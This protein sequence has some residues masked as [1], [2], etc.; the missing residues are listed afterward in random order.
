[1]PTDSDDLDLVITI[2]VA[3]DAAA[4]VVAGLQDA[5]LAVKDTLAS[6]G[7]V[8]GSA[9]PAAVPALREVPGVQAVEASRDVGIP[10]DS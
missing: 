9:P 5:G 6:A 7:V 2:D 1:M 4:S 10:E 3:E 8:T